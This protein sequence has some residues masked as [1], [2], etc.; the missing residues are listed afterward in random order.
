MSETEEQM[1]VPIQLGSGQAFDCASL[2]MTTTAKIA[3]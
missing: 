3:I 2:W 1:Q